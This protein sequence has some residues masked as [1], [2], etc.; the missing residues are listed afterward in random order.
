MITHKYGESL[1]LIIAPSFMR[2]Q[3]S[4]FLEQTCLQV[5]GSFMQ[6]IPMAASSLETSVILTALTKDSA[7]LSSQ[8]VLG[9]LPKF[10]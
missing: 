10:L 5:E 7:G 3:K 2:W 9:L 4:V 1:R 6:V 8:L